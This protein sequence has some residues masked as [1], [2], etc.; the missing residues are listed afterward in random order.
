MPGIS[1]FDAAR[2]IRQLQS[3]NRNQPIVGITSDENDDERF[4]CLDAGMNDYYQKSIK[5]IYIDYIL[6]DWLV[7]SESKSFIAS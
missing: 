3:Q 7:R 6:E 4:R 2:G 1:G 5:M